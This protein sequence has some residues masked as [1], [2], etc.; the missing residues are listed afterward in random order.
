MCKVVDVNDV[1]TYPK[2]LLNF[3]ENHKYRLETTFNNEK[4]KVDLDSDLGK[5]LRKFL[6]GRSFC[7]LHATKTANIRNFYNNGLL[8][9]AKSEI[10]IE[11]ILIPLKKCLD[12]NLFKKI[13]R[14]IR[15]R[16]TND[17]YETIWFTFGQ[18][19]DIS[20]ENGF[21]M[22]DNYGGEFLEDAFYDLD[23]IDF[24]KNSIAVLGK[25]YAILFEIKFEM[26][27]YGLQSEILNYMMNKI[28]FN[29]DEKFFKEGYIKNN[30]E[31]KN[32]LDIIEIKVGDKNE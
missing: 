8:I 11:N 28:L 10:L 29:S 1:N 32:I 12:I 26:L 13:E 3:C 21:F 22:A 24:Y 6:I 17:K 30:I 4:V 15:A 31:P 25:S 9:P 7:A 18:I 16:V 5:K 23:L 2:K 14:K 27:E 20:I 19:E